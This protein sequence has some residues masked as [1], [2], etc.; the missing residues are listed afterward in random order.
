MPPTRRHI[1]PSTPPPQIY[2]VIWMV[3]NSIPPMPG[4]MD[5]QNRPNYLGFCMIVEGI[6]PVR[7]QV[8]VLYRPVSKCL[9]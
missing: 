6:T 7:S 3:S 8:R 1:G 5:F 2:T 9:E 4:G